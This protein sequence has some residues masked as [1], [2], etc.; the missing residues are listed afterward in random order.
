VT[1]SEQLEAI[2]QQILDLLSAILIPDWSFL[3][4]LIPIVL[5][6]AVIGP[7]L[8]LLVLYHLGYQAKKPRTRAR[9]IEY[10]QPVPV[11]PDG[12]PMRPTG[13]PFCE[14][15][16]LV[17]GSAARRCD[18]C[19]D[20]LTLLC[21]RCAVARDA[22]IESCGNCGMTGRVLDRALAVAPAGPPSGG[23]ATA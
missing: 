20:A 21:P 23:A 19:H 5:V 9:Y 15:D 2:W 22:A 16:L 14:R 12:Q 10:P 13:R 7:I 6:L 11:G 18:A 8:T 17:Y 4:S 3:V 1:F